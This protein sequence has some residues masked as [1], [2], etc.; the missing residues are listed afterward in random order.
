[1]P[2]AG[3]AGPVGT[4]GREE[5]RHHSCFGCTAAVTGSSLA[6]PSTPCHKEA[7]GRGAPAAGT[8]YI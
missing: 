7:G 5:R 2:A 1:M 4:E 8:M 3:S 6:G